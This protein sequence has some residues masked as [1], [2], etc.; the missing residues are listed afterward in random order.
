[1]RCKKCG[2]KAVAHLRAYGIALCETCYPSFYLRLVS[3]SIRRYRILKKDERILAAVS[4]GKDSVAMISALTELG[5]KADVLYIDLGIGTYSEESERSVFNLAKQL[6]VDI[7][8]VRLRDYGFTIDDVSRRSIRKT[9]SACGVSKRY[10][11][12]RF[13]RENRYDVIATGHT[14]EDVASFYLKNVAGGS[15]LWVEKLAPR[16]EPFDAKIVA[17]AK[18]LFEMSE[19][20][21]LIYV[22]LRQLPFT[23]LECPHSPSPDWKEIV[24]EIERRKPGFT[25]NFVRGL[26]SPRE[27][28][29]EI[30]YCC[31]CGEVTNAEICSFCRIR[32]SFTS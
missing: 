19:K 5:Y 27:E 3:R 9:C 14:V 1:M 22:L 10:I 26:I 16:N 15:K 17:R 6:G 24:Y 12:N 2:K 11:M 21:N 20:E 28:F 30:K 4:G 18:P 32:R 8:I 31:I 25:K 7:H 29:G 13:A 23:A